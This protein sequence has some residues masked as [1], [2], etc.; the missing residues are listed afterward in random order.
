MTKT[1]TLQE[2][3]EL[4]KKQHEEW[5]NRIVQCVPFSSKGLQTENEFFIAEESTPD[6]YRFATDNINIFDPSVAQDENESDAN[7]MPPDSSSPRCDDSFS[8]DADDDIVI[9]P[10][11]SPRGSDSDDND[12]ESRM[13]KEDES[14]KIEAWRNK[15]KNM[16]NSKKQKKIEVE[17]VMEEEE[18]K[19]HELCDE[20]DEIAQN[21]TH[22]VLTNSPPKKSIEQTDES[23]STE[24]DVTTTTP[25]TEETPV[26]N[27]AA[28]AAR[29]RRLST[30]L[31][32]TSPSQRGYVNKIR[33]NIMLVGEPGCGKSSFLKSFVDPLDAAT[34]SNLY[35]NL[36][37]EVTVDRE[38]I[39]VHS[40]EV[41]DQF[42]D[43]GNFEWRS[44]NNNIMVSVVL[45]TFLIIIL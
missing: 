7:V 9:S 4:K 44:D 20:I 23:N 12:M 15:R 21:L 40:N 28:I 36:A 43:L 19:I 34:D 5:R 33:F 42:N 45:S 30:A 11:S 2:R 38:P 22:N 31:I 27:A 10:R 18:V 8:A 3:R 16:H 29:G 37:K 1:L 32:R 13:S 24:D 39:N 14:S 6:K 35:M 17:Q 25:P 26:E 41:K